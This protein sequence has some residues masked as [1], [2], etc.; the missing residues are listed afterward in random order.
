MIICQA[1]DFDS[2]VQSLEECETLTGNLQVLLAILGAL[3]PLKEQKRKEFQQVG[4]PT[5]RLKKYFSETPSK[6]TAKPT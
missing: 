4:K 6:T 5:V 2:C 1:A 3:G